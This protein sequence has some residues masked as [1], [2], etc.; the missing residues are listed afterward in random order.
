MKDIDKYS[1]SFPFY[2]KMQNTLKIHPNI[3]MTFFTSHTRIRS[4]IYDA[5]IVDLKS[6][7]N[8]TTIIYSIT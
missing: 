3:Y 2:V 7:R 5:C 6:K 8:Y 1:V 4:H